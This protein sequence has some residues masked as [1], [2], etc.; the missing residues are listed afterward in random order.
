[1]N[2]EL[3]KELDQAERDAWK[4]LA[5]Y[6]FWMFGYF[7][8]RWVFLNRILKANRPNPFKRLV[9]AAREVSA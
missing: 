1:V 3:L 9:L 5:R 6:K 2:E 8:G 4:N 7:A